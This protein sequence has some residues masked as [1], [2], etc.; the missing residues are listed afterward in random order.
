MYR[1]KQPLSG[2]ALL[3]LILLGMLAGIIFLIYDNL[4]FD[5][6]NR[7]GD[8]SSPPVIDTT[9]ETEFSVDEIISPETTPETTI[10][11]PA[12]ASS[13]RG[14]AT[15]G[16]LFIPSAGILAPIVDVYLDGTSWDVS[17]LGMNVGHLQGTA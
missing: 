6:F 9:P 1:R 16:T 7:S 14:T 13:S 10:P 11:A 2:C 12:D 15:G 4:S 17:G 8:D 5:F 3:Q